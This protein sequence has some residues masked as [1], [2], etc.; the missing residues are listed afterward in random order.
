MESAIIGLV[1]VALGALLT[2]ARELW[3]SHRE[4]K[5]RAEYLAIRVTCIL[6][7]YSSSCVEVA[8]DD[9]ERY[10]RDEQGCIRLESLPPEICFENLD[11]DWH[12]LPSSLMY[13]VLNF[14]SHI[15][16]AN[17]IISSVF[18][19]VA[20]PPDYDEGVEERQFQY[21][22]LGILAHELASDLRNKYG[23]PVKEYEN[24]NPID[25][26][27]ET[28]SKIEHIRDERAKRHEE[29]LKH[30]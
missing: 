27:C 1:G 11:V 12:S 15:E 14:P 17:G 21:S 26:M 23:M 22:K 4:K 18:E 16:E 30:A 5:K 19:F 2:V 24:W 25:Y 3:I 6:E 9:G 28:K 7:R 29:V 10:G 20:F 13:R 8:G